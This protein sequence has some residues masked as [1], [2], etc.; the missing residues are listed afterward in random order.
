VSADG[1]ADAPDVLGGGTDRGQPLRPARRIA[2]LLVSRSAEQAVLGIGSVLL[3]RV[4]GLEEFAPI[5]V[6]LIV[7]SMALTLSDYGLGADALRLEAGRLASRGELRRVRWRNMGVAVVT[8]VLGGVIGGDVGVVVAIGGLLWGA[9]AESFVRRSAA[10]RGGAV[11]SVVRSELAGASLLAVGVVAATTADEHALTVFG[12]ALVAKQLVEVVV[13]R[14]WREQF[15]DVE[16]VRDTRILWWAQVVAY[17]IANVDYLILG[18][19]QPAEVFSVYVLAF[20]LA[21][22][23]PSQLSFVAGRVLSVDLAAESDGA[24]QEVYRRYTKTLFLLGSGGAV[25]TGILAQLL[26][27][28]LGEEWRTITWVLTALACSVPWRM[29]LGVAGTLAVVAQRSQDLLTLELIHLTLLVAA[30]AAAAAVELRAFVVTVG[31]SVVIANLAYHRVAGRMAGIRPWSQ[32]VP[33][34]GA[35][36]VAIGAAAWQIGAS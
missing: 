5:S 8:L 23:L 20:R 7:N 6:L 11:G 13:V 25:A 9:S 28:V 2:P 15:A 31:G 21:N 29:V 18:L 22:A 3:A 10:L 17:A 12:L 19:F 35:T 4:L 26:P 27:D 24:R 16:P 14:T 34:A 32:L 33:L 36:L 30:Y 1:T